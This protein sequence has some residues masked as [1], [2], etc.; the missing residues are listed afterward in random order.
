MARRAKPRGRPIAKARARE[1][2]SVEAGARVVR[3][4][5]RSGLSPAEFC[6]REG[7]DRQRLRRW[8]RKR[9]EGSGDTALGLHPVRV[10]GAP[11]RCDGVLELEL[12]QGPRLRI[13]AGCDEA[14][15]ACV[16]RLLASPA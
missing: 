1:R 9:V 14:T 7:L 8:R 3:A 16:L 15:L 13:P 10:V 11:V 6:R 4:W 2:W 12:P 5:E